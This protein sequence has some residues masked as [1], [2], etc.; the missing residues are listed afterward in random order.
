M[1]NFV[2][3]TS[4]ELTLFYYFYV[5]LL[6]FMTAQQEIS[7]DWEQ[8]SQTYYQ[9]RRSLF[10]THMYKKIIKLANENDEQSY[11]SKKIIVWCFNISSKMINF[12]I[13]FHIQWDVF[14]QIKFHPW[15][16]FSLFHPGMKRTWKQNFLIPGWDFISVTCKRTGSL[17]KFFLQ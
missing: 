11:F 8:L 7:T 9:L 14:F 6:R 10:F 17:P 15:M 16:K 5:L 12:I 1:F 13:C 4:L 3:N 2:L